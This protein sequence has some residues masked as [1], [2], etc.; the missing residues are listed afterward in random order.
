MLAR[1]HA[2]QDLREELDFHLAM[3]ARKHQSAGVDAAEASRRARIEFGNIE[4]VKEDARDVRGGRLLEEIAA[5]VQYG[6][7][8]LR[9]SPGFALAV[10]LTIGLGVGINASA[11]T[12]FNAY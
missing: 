4:L 11:F 12:I 5:D 10:I 2:E 3:Q 1:R 6:L 8:G 7:R 9:R